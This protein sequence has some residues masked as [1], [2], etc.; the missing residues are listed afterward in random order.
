M[1]EKVQQETGKRGLLTVGEMARLFH[2]N[3]RTLRYYDQLG[4]LKPEYV[5]PETKYRYYSTNQFERMNTIKYLRALDVPLEKIASFFNEKD[6][7]TML[8]IFAD[9]R[10]RVLE[11]QRQLIQ[12]ERKLTNR[13]EQIQAALSAPYGQVTVK[14]LPQRELVLLEKDFTLADDLE[15][16]IRDLSRDHRLDEAIF[17]GKVG[18]SISQQ[19]LEKNQIKRFSSIFL[20]LEAEDNFAESDGALPAASYAT[21]QYQGTHQAAAPYYRLLLDYLAARGLKM[22]GDSVEITIIDWGMTNDSNKF[23]TELQ[24]PFIAPKMLKF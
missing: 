7:N 19:D 20:V 8:S 2:M 24:I 16:L 14:Q 10:E 12:I 13:M 5:N 17:L 11:K 15:L 18:V 21:V 9:Q 22:T 1:T 4:I 23:V 3:I 6:V